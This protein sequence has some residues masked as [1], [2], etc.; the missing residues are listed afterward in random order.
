MISVVSD[1]GSGSGGDGGGA[2]GIGGQL[3]ASIASLSMQVT[4]G[5]VLAVRDTLLAKAADLDAGLRQ[6]WNAAT[7]MPQLGGDP[8]SADASVAFPVRTR[9]LLAYCQTYVGR[10][11]DA[12]HALDATA[13]AYGLTEEDIANTSHAVGRGL[14]AGPALSS[15]LDRILNPGLYGDSLHGDS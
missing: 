10:L 7:T 9:A 14:V 1:Q 6:H 2:A 3:G 11:R 15:G 13:R 12:A 4:S 5:N 8:V